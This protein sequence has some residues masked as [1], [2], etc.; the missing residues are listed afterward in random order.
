VW[1]P[2]ELGIV[3]AQRDLTLRVGSAEHP[4][5]VSVGQPVREPNPDANAPWWCPLQVE[6]LGRPVRFD[7][8][9]GVDSL[10]SF[11]LALQYARR[12]LPFWA[13]KENGVLIWEHEDLDVIFD[14][15]DLT[16]SYGKMAGEVLAAA[17]EALREQGQPVDASAK[18][19]M[20][21]L[22]EVVE[23]YGT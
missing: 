7:A 13:S 15:S 9:G 3:V 17:R 12:M 22:R 20:D 18:R 4:V 14:S 5:T 8:I 23:K 1:K 2:T 10:H 11:L 6:G 21:R 16:E 19:S